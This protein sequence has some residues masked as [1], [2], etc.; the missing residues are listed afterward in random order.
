VSAE[1]L[2]RQFPALGRSTAFRITSPASIRYNCIA[3]AASDDTRWWWPSSDDGFWPSE[4]ARQE[5]VD[6]F[7]RAYA[8]LGYAECASAEPEEGFEKVALYALGDEP[9]HAA[10]QLAR[11]AWTSKLGR[12]EDIEHRLEDLEGPLYGKV[13]KLFK[14]PADGATSRPSAP[15]GARP[16]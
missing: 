11:G 1:A 12:S 2:L 3:W 14:R 4:V 15:R 8:T 13:V 16:R 7:I 6:V 9:R 10:R 5:T